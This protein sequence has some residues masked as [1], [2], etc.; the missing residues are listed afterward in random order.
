[1]NYFIEEEHLEIAGKNI[2]TATEIAT[3]LPLQGS[4]AF[5]KFYAANRWMHTFLPN[6]YLRVSSAKKIKSLWIKWIPE[7]VL[8]NVIGDILDKLLM[9][10]TT[11][12][13]ITKTSKRKIGMSATKY[14]AK[15]SDVNFQ[16]KFI[17]LYERKVFELLHKRTMVMKPVI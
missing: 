13:R 4:V 16:N 10:I 2:Y 6:K 1:M 11:K 3:L 7:K 14:C 17:D 9:R 15:P 12:R 8:N 5:E